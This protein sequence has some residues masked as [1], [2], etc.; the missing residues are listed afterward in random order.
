MID[1]HV[2]DSDLATSKRRGLTRRHVVAGGAI[3]LLSAAVV[4]APLLA[5]E[6]SGDGDGE[7]A[8]NQTGDE[9]RDAT[10]DDRAAE[11]E[12]RTAERAAQ[13]PEVPEILLLLTPLER[14][15]V[16]LSER[17]LDRFDA[18]AFE[19]DGQPAA[20]REGLVTMLEQDRAH[21]DLLE[22]ALAERGATSNP[23]L[24]DDGDP[25]SIADYLERLTNLKAVSVMGYA[26]AS[27][28]LNNRTLLRVALGLQTVEARH[29]A[30]LATLL[31]QSPFPDAIDPVISRNL[32]V[33]ILE[34]NNLSVLE[35][36][37]TPEAEPEPDSG[38][39]AESQFDDLLADAARQ[40]EVDVAD[41]ELATVA[42]RDWPDS[43]LGCA[44][45]GEVAADVITPGYLV[46][47]TDGEREIEY[48]TDRSGQFRQC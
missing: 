15:V 47:V 38:D 48:H 34:E 18:A 39:G 14:T 1:N 36:A 19:A 5:Q 25:G 32:L 7:T 10:R 17:G 20:L 22:Q 46:I 3:S 41:L 45:S 2:P 42:E 30:F 29:A 23:P 31:D 13:V 26:T 6:D 9:G 8:G 44:E 33:E 21:L 11:R 40:L 12:A 35:P 16:G 27:W 37:G 28:G 24:V 43:A 4:S